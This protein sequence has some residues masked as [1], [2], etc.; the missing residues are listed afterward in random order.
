LS[1]PLAAAPAVPFAAG[2][3]EEI[4]AAEAGEVA[5]AM[6]LLFFLRPSR[7]L[8]ADSKK[9]VC[10]GRRE[11]FHKCSSGLADINDEK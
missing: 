5:V 11:I 8:W 3:A 1:K 7:T 9:N 10:A 6:F 2:A 4:N